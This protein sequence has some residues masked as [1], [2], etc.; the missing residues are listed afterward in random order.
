MFSCE[1]WEIFESMF[2][3]TEHL[4]ATASDITGIFPYNPPNVF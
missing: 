3:F 1:F 4:S 2:F